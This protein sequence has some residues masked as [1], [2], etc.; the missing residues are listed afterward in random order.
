MK[1]HRQEKLF[2]FHKVRLKARPLRVPQGTQPFQFHKVRLK[3]AG[4]AGAVMPMSRFNSI[5]Y[6]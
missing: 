2:Q 5:R 6:D 3:E 1:M 4:R